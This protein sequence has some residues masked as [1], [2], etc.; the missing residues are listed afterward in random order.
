M[1]STLLL[2]IAVTLFIFGYRF[3][4]K[5]MSVWVFRL[6][7]NYSTPSQIQTEGVERAVG[8]RHLVFGHYIASLG[9]IATIMGTGITVIWG[10]I[11][12]FLW[13]VVAGTLVAGVYGLSHLWLGLRQQGMSLPLLAGKLLGDRAR[14]AFFLL[15]FPPLLLVNALFAVSIAQLLTD[16]PAAV[17]P[18][19]L[20]I[21]IALGL[22]LFL[23]KRA[24]F[25]IIPA[26]LIALLAA[27]I[28]IY[29]GGK[30]PLAF[31]GALD[32]HVLNTPV[33]SL[34]AT[35]A[36][37][38][39]LFIYLFFTARLPVWKLARARGWLTALQ[40]GLML[41]V[42]V[43]G[44]LVLHPPVVAPEFHSPEHSPAAL[45]WLFAMLTGGAIAG[46][47]ALAAGNIGAN[48]LAHETDARYLGFGGA[49]FDGALA[50]SALII[51]AAGFD[52]LEA[53]RLYYSA[54]QTHTP[55]Q[56][57]GGYIN[58][59]SHFA[60]ALGI[61]RQTASPIVAVIVASLAATGL[62]AGVRFQ[63]T[64]VTEMKLQE[65]APRSN[66]LVFALT[67]AI[68]LALYADKTDQGI[69]L[70]PLLGSASLICTGLILLLTSVVLL[71]LKR[72]VIFVLAP[73]VLLLLAANWALV[74]QFSLWWLH[75]QWLML[76]GG[77]CLFVLQ[78]WLL[79]EGL[80]AL[81]KSQNAMPK[82]DSAPL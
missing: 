6:D 74:S 65:R 27:G 76:S 39:L 32:L 21:P 77:A 61:D 75:E 12:A 46:F 62:E 63:K 23:H 56:I 69:T 52:N 28:L 45:P 80:Q 13:L 47:Y 43:I 24:D 11:P 33:F 40:L 58:G 15:I 20:Q 36:W 4:S 54:W 29:L 59:V 38:L 3:Y 67:F 42:T 64:L 70:W 7:H 82:L 48:Q 35:T 18:F 1:N 81:K 73:A 30:I 26:T 72:A 22:G 9:G 2:L 16:F 78:V 44:I 57:L 31:N 8:N 66:G 10:W 79:V 25:E 37:I 60:G 51:Y 71:R 41:A 14:R 17:L 49:L 5:L 50:L 19:W 55:A 68:A 53:W 34:D